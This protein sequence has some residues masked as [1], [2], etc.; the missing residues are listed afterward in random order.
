MAVPAPLRR[1]L[2]R[3]R[4]AVPADVRRLARTWRAVRSGGPVTGVPPFRRVL[5]IA[6]HP[7]DESLGCAGTM[8]L[9]SDQGATVTTLTASDGEA[10]Q[11]SSLPA[12]EIA[13]TRRAEAQ[14]AAA[15]VGASAHFLGLPDGGLAQHP[16]ELAS[17]LRKAIGELEPEAV[18][19]PWPLDGGSDHRAVAQAL[20]GVLDRGG[21][22]VWGYE[23]WTALV[24]NRFVEITAVI[25]RKRAAL[26]AHETAALALD[27]SAAEGLARW[28]SLQTLGGRGFA[29]AFLALPAAGYRELAGQLGS[30]PEMTDS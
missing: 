18:F 6:P 29:E 4:G 8:A 1:T 13:R 3:A 24:P 27:L 22:E 12:E 25:E 28:R 21:P 11:G 15:E 20:A 16:N 17:G 30:D 19:A 14:R 23:V 10:T 5:V 9:L 2:H 7:D 26:G